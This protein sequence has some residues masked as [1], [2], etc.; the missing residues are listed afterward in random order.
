MQLEKTVYL[1]AA[2]RTP[3]AKFGG[4]LAKLT[5]ADLGVASAKATLARSG[6]DPNAV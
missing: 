4:A 5:A 1:I 2:V 3:I 6:I